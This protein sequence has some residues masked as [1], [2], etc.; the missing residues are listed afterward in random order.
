MRLRSGVTSSALSTVTSRRGHSMRVAR[1]MRVRW[2]G[3]RIGGRWGRRDVAEAAIVEGSAQGLE[4]EI[5]GG[6]GAEADDHAT[7]DV[8]KGGLGAAAWGSWG[9]GNRL[10]GGGIGVGGRGFPGFRV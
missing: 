8:I 10:G 5:G 1:G 4:E 7:G 9:E 3:A 2:R 6:T